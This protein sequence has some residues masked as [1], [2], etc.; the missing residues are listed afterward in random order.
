M[1]EQQYD[2][3]FSGQ[4][5]DGHFADFVK[6]DIQQLFKADDAYIAALFSGTEQVIKR[7]VDKPTA[8]KFQQAFK[9]AGAKLVAKL[10]QP[11]SAQAQVA[12][13]STT[14]TAPEKPQ[15]QR[16]ATV[17]NAP[18]PPPSAAVKPQLVAPKTANEFTLTTEVVAGE[19]DDAL[20]EHHQ[21]ELCAPETLPNWDLSA[22]GSA[23]VEAEPFVPADIDTSNLTVADAGERLTPPAFEAPDP[24]INTDAISLAPNQGEIENLPDERQPVKVDTSH[25]S[26]ES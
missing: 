19:S 25:L 15:A 1:A 20:I 6:A 3:L 14:P 22:A 2:L 7:Q 11:N 10:H 8:I 5:L 23:L 18:T 24:I 9:K 17:S 26:V 4:L 21:P 16:A 12:A 13:E